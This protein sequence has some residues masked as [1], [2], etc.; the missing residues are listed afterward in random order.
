M[1]AETAKTVE[2][3]ELDLIYAISDIQKFV[4]RVMIRES[5]REDLTLQQAT[6]LR[7][8]GSMGP[9]PMNRISRQLLTTGANI[10]GLIDRMEQKGLVERAEDRTDRRKILIQ[11]TSK[12]QKTFETTAKRYRKKIKESFGILPR[13]EREE[14]FRLLVKVRDEL[15][16][17]DISEKQP[18]NSQT[19]EI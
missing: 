14:L 8:L 15:Y 19:E 7:I 12:G 17:R 6:I 13:S 2:K 1:T 9:L 18:A 16:R 3:Q 10:T 5:L 4:S 11:L